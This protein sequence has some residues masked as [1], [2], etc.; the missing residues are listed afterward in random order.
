MKL[1]RIARALGKSMLGL[2]AAG[3]FAAA[4]M[5]LAQG[6]AAA[7]AAAPPPVVTTAPAPSLAIAPAPADAANAATVSAETAQS[8]RDE[9]SK[10]A[11]PVPAGG[12]YVPMAPTPG[13]GMPV[14]GRIG[15]QEQFSPIGEYGRWMHDGILLPLIFAI[16]VFVL[17]LILYAMFRFRR[18]AN[19]VPSKTTHN[20]LIEV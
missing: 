7:P 18:S 5:A 6:A 4:P 14:D 16:S 9:A 17:A 20:A 1:G 10:T 2:A 3:M 8:A 11:A 13:I 19:P 12:G 15:L